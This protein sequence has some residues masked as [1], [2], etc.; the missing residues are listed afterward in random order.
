M[1]SNLRYT[2]EGV[3]IKIIDKNPPEEYKWTKGIATRC[4]KWMREKHVEIF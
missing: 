4:M 2:E 3:N 1:V